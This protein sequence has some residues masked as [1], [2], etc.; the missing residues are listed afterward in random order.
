MPRAF[1][2]HPRT[3]PTTAA[4]AAGLLAA[5]LVFTPRLHAQVP[6]GA[7]PPAVTVTGTGE[8]E[9]VPDRARLSLG[10]STQAAT[11]AEASQQNARLQRAVLDA[12]RAQGVP[13]E[14]I[15]TNGYNVS[16]V[17]DYNQQ[18]RRTRVT[19]YTVQNTVNVELRRIDQVG[20]V[21]DAVLAKGANTVSS[22]QFYS[23]QAEAARRRALARAV[24]RARADADAMAAAAGGRLGDLLEL[25]SATDVRPRPVMMDMMARAAPAPATPISEGTETVTA[26]VTARWR[27][28]AGR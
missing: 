3:T 25:S 15:S 12:V 13:A 17:T 22:L 19:G 28:F 4:V 24:E 8:D 27:F 6:I 9:V 16:P 10:V 2:Y 11:A 7:F 23:S 5:A 14:Q 1:S 20:P 18:T 21:L 26:S